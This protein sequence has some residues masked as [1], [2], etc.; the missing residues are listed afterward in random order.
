MKIL[1]EIQMAFSHQE[2]KIVS[3]MIII[4]S[5]LVVEDSQVRSSILISLKRKLTLVLT[6][7]IELNQL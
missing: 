4:L 5:I 2:I 7:E 1:H 6:N 3:E